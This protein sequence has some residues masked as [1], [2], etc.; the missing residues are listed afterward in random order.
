M[1][2]RVAT[3]C[4]ILA[5]VAGCSSKTPQTA[6]EYYDTANSHWRDGA[7]PLAIEHY[8][9]LLDQHPFSELAPEAEFRIAHAHFQNRS[10]PAAIA[11]FS[12]FQ[13][14]HPTSPL[15]PLVGYLIGVCHEKQMQKPNRD[16]SASESAHAYYQA[17]I[18]QYPESP[19]A[20]LAQ[21]RLHLCRESLAQ[22]EINVAKYY[23]ER[24]ND[25][26]AEVR[27]IDLIKR[28]TETDQAAEAMYA[29]AGI[30]RDR[31]EL[32]KAALAYGA[33][34]YHHPDHNLAPNADAE[35][36]EIV[37][38]QDRPAGDPVAALLARSGRFREFKTV[39]A[40]ELDKTAESATRV[41]LAPS[42]LSQPSTLYDPMENRQ[43][44]RRYE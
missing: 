1:T 18:N 36:S 4:A 14:R 22:H 42:P 28:Y 20:D 13:R 8:R 40:R 25:K 32:D 31:E 21:E 7:Y 35:M 3:L 33:L 27:I 2:K 10:C 23:H 11:G 5:L 30:Y 9:E 24:A 6:E 37:D 44:N 34:L 15:L 43:R 17:V 29:L 19:F 39:D 12:D 16:Q 41:P 38:V 26:A